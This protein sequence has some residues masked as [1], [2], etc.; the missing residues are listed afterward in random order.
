[1]VVLSSFLLAALFIL[2]TGPLNRRRPGS[3][4]RPVTG[5]QTAYF[6]SGCLAYL[7]ALSPPMDDWSDFY[8]L[9]AHMFQHMIVIF[10]VAPLF[11]AG[12][13]GWVLQPLANNRFTNPIGR[14]LTR[15]VVAAVVSTVIVILWHLPDAYDAA[16][17]HQPLHIAQHGFFLL[18][19]LLAWWPVL[20]PLPA[21]PRIESPPVRCVYLFLY[22]LPA[23]LVGAFITMS[24]PGVYP[25][26]TNV[27]RIFG[28]DL[29][30][31]QQLAGLMMWVG[32]SMIYFL[33]ITVIFLTWAS[34]E[35]AADREPR[36][37][38]PV[39]APV[40]GA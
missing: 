25:Y 5:R 26:Y 13:P 35:E 29:A 10:V 38:V 15:P 17:N 1:M 23:G 39:P 22:S 24:A 20:G 37:S 21:W 2:W 18:A 11:L 8:L 36:G 30:M 32:G 4:N 16:L 33:W 28:I 31:D 12:I 14:T 7:I 19:G 40:E 27:E 6:L 34:R 9:T 3:E